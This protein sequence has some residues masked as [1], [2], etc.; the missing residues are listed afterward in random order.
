M[1]PTAR[2]TNHGRIRQWA[3]ERGGKPAIIA[4]AGRDASGILRIDFGEATEHLQTLSWDDFFNIFEEQGLEFLYQERM[5]D[6]SPS[7]FFRFV[8]RELESEEEEDARIEDG[9]DEDT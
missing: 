4:T 5:A 2:T 6:G 1:G 3:E 9:G 8:T 7:R